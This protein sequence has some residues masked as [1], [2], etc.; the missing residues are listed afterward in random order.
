MITK[1]LGIDIGK[2]NTYLCLSKAIMGDYLF[3][4]LLGDIKQK[5]NENNNV[6]NSFAYFTRGVAR[7]IKEYS[8]EHFLHVNNKNKPDTSSEQLSFDI[9]N[10][11]DITPL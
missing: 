7:N 9:P 8:E 1:D 10:V 2:S 5:I 6:N 11:G 4:D 3:N